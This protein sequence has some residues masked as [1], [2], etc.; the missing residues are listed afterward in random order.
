MGFSHDHRKTTTLVEGLRLSETS[1]GWYS[2]GRSTES[3]SSPER[4]VS[5]PSAL[6]GKLVDLFQL[7]EC[8]NHS[9]SCGYDP[10]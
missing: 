7:A 8:A 4:T 9:S 2:M 5:A 6:I 3:V 10:V 1:R